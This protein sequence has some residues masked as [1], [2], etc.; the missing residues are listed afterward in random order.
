MYVPPCTAT[1]TLCRTEHMCAQNRAW[2]RAIGANHDHIN[3]FMAGIE[4]AKKA[5]AISRSMGNDKGKKYNGP[6]AETLYK[7]GEDAMRGIRVQERRKWAELRL[8]AA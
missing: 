3:C 7:A 4:K 2:N 6:S 8:R 5:V 1:P